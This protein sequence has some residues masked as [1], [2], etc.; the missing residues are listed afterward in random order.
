M[1]SL[2]GEGT[3]SLSTG[4]ELGQ[5]ARHTDCAQTDRGRQT[6]RQTDRQIDKQTDRQTDRQ[7]ETEQTYTRTQALGPM[8]TQTQR[9]G[10]GDTI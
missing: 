9:S 7:Y 5:T 2:T 1:P 4:A 6:D 10:E 3:I 8:D